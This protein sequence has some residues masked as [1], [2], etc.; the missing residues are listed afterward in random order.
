MTG[1]VVAAGVPVSAGGQ[2]VHLTNDTE[3]G[4]AAES[5]LTYG[6]GFTANQ[7]MTITKLGALCRTTFIGSTASVRLG[8]WSNSA[9]LLASTA[10]TT[11][12][13]SRLEGDALI[14][15]TSSLSVSSGTVYYF[16]L[17]L[18]ATA[19]NGKFLGSNSG[20][21]VP[22]PSGYFAPASTPGAE[23]GFAKP[24]AYS[25][26]NCPNFVLQTA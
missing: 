20:N 25:V 6:G 23:D 9:T 15:L 4:T 2:I 12:T 26:P 11:V 13:L 3:N 21:V 1:A 22:F 14:P 8:I 24:G 17:F 16:G 5:N 18:S 19:D 7:S 10:L